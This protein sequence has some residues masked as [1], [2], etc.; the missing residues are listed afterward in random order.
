M[1]PLVDQDGHRVSEQRVKVQADVREIVV[2]HTEVL[3][4]DASGEP[5]VTVSR[6]THPGAGLAVEVPE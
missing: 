2:R 6:A 4:L 3:F 1:T 5:V